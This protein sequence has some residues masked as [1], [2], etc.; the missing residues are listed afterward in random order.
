MFGWWR[1]LR[2][3]RW[4]AQG[5]GK[6]ARSW[7]EALPLFHDLSPA[8]MK[9]L[10]GLVRVFLEEKHFEGC[11][12]LEMRDKIR[13]VIA[14][15]ACLLVLNLHHDFFHRVRT[16]LVYPSTFEHRSAWRRHDGV[17]EQQSQAVLGEAW[18]GGPVVLAWDSSYQGG[19]DPSD[20]QNT[21]VHEFAHKLDMLDGITDGIPPLP[22]RTESEAWREEFL[23]LY[24]SFAQRVS[25]GRTGML[26]AYGATHEGEFFAT[27]SEVFF[28][29]AAEM[30]RR[31]AELYGLL[32][33]FYRQDPARRGMAA[34]APA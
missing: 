19:R 22:T 5:L 11:G 8:E 7:L 28:E 27:A 9:R 1:D 13:V 3:R 24:Q 32:R 25:A 12:G 6:E 18:P 34:S 10:E 29:Q 2:R 14:A 4:Q 15:Q 30:Q 23:R 20:G 26:D 17:V 33:T 31:E 21:V 16:I